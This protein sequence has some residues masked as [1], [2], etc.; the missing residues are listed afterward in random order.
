MGGGFAGSSHGAPGGR[1]AEPDTGWERRLP[2]QHVSIR[3]T[4]RL[5]CI[6]ASRS[7]GPIADSCDNA[8]VEALN[9]TFKAELI[10][11]Q[12]PWKDVDQVERAVFQRVTWFN[13]E[14][15]HSALDHVPPAECEGDF[16]RSRQQ[17]LSVAAGTVPSLRPEESL[18]CAERAVNSRQNPPN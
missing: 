2:G 8:M 4:D 6:G 18:P 7:V 14:R 12:G 15:L 9:G 10:E 5:V 1:R 3:Y 13:E 17:A 11:T 16:W